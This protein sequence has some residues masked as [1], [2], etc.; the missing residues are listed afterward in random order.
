MIL[1]LI[2]TVLWVGSEIFL[3]RFRRADE[4]RQK[5]DKSSLRFIWGTIFISTVAGPMLRTAGPLISPRYSAY[6]YD[7]G[8]FLI[9]IGLILRWIAILTLKSSFTVDVAVSE[10]QAIIQSGVY[11][12]I[13]HPAYAGA[14]LSFFGLGFL[15]NSY[16][17]LV[18]VFVPVFAAFA[19]R[20]RVE[21]RL[22]T[23]VFKDQ[24]SAYM[25]HTWRLIPGIY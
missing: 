9:C 23:E 18:V 21:E 6:I 13:R 5:D 11:K 20:M 14:L 12:Y 1:L 15:F 19:Y 3:A 10:N 8:I 16:L 4:S 17:T 24:Y 22:L 25:D 2:I 7:I